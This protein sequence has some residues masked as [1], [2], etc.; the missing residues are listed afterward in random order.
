[1]GE[2]PALRNQCRAVASRSAS[3]SKRR[4]QRGAKS[5]IC[6]SPINET[7]GASQYIRAELRDSFLARGLRYPARGSK[8]GARH[9]SALRQQGQVWSYADLRWLEPEVQGHKDGRRMTPVSDGHSADR[10]KLGEG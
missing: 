10:P 3:R 1:V 5:T 7:C 2:L 6:V 8:A 9:G 4:S